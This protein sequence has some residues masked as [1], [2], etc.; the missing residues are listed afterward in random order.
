[1]LEPNTIILR[2]SMRKYTENNFERDCLY[3][4]ILD[5]NKYRHGYLNR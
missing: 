3:L 4:D 1:M 5:R 2:K